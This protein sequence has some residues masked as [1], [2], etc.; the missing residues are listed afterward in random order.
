[1]WYDDQAEEAAGLYTS[2]LRDGRLGDVVRYD[3]VSAGPSGKVPGSVMTVEFEA[4]GQSFMA[5]NGGPI[6]TFNEATS[7]VLYRDTQEEIDEL[8]AALTEGGQE[9]PCGWLKDRFGVSWQLVPSDLPSLMASDDPAAARR[10]T[11]ALF[12]MRKIDIEALRRA[13]AGEYSPRQANA[14][15][16]PLNGRRE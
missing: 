8:W 11:E 9:Q 4:E 12:S 16:R 3:E 13:K 7:L 6:F 1:L 5:L 10:V 14:S 2:V 15:P